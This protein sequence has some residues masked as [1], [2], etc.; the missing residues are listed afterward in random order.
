MTTALRLLNL[1]PVNS[2]APIGCHV[3]PLRSIAPN[4]SFA[5]RKDETIE[6]ESDDRL[7]SELQFSINL[8]SHL[9]N[10][11]A[12][13]H[14]RWTLKKR[15][16]I[17]WWAW[18]SEFINHTSAA[19]TWQKTNIFF[20]FWGFRVWPV[21]LWWLGEEWWSQDECLRG[22]RVCSAVD[23]RAWCFHLISSR[24]NKIH[25]NTLGKQCKYSPPARYDLSSAY[26]C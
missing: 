17:I 14:K 16:M 11:C 7:H 22:C 18:Q 4:Y 8:Y 21:H 15:L 5:K 9:E 1:K 23:H 13:S 10:W 3:L 20:G 26:R 25:N 12:P 6:K 2:A 19:L 24:C